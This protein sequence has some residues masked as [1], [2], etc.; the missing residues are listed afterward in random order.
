[1]QN[2]I[3]RGDIE[4]DELG[5]LNRR[6]GSVLKRHKILP[7]FA[8]QYRI[9]EAGSSRPDPRT[10]RRALA[11]LAGN[12]RPRH[13]RLSSGPEVFADG[14]YAAAGT[15]LEE[16][17]E[18]RAELRSTLSKLTNVSGGSVSK[19]FVA[20]VKACLGR[21]DLLPPEEKTTRRICQGF[22]VE[23]ESTVFEA[24]NGRGVPVCIWIT[25]DV[26][27]LYP[28]DPRLWSF[29]GHAVETGRAP[30]IV[31]RKISPSTFSVFKAVG[32]RGTQYYAFLEIGSSPQR[33]ADE[34]KQVGWLYTLPAKNLSNHQVASHLISL[35]AAARI[36]SAVCAE[37]IRDALKAGLGDKASPSTGGQLR[38]WAEEHDI[39]APPIFWIS[40]DRWREYAGYRRR[41]RSTQHRGATVLAS[42]AADQVVQA[43]TDAQ[44]GFGR[45]TQVTRVPFTIR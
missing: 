25:H 41:T 13:G 9:C 15:T 34:A 43:V 29:L 36:P 2:L 17:E 28:D 35:A 7:F 40:L 3:L 6:I 44:R 14:L 33:V 31:A 18:H 23:V 20:L 39:Q 38:A 22:E 1:M 19:D 4:T 26:E 27:W 10:L 37:S 30:L 21:A 42:T 11:E 12:Q 8:L 45:K 16:L 5:E 32:A 24:E